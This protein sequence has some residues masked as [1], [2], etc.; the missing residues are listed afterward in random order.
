[1]KFIIIAI[2]FFNL[3]TLSFKILMVAMLLSGSAVIG[4]AIYHHGAFDDRCVSENT[5]FF[6]S[7]DKKWYAKVD[8]LRC[9]DRS[10]RDSVSLLRQLNDRISILV[11][12]SA[13]NADTAN[14]INMMKV[15]W[16]AADQ[17]SI[18]TPSKRDLPVKQYAGINVSYATY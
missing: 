4:N 7:P 14:E 9:A 15:V 10:G 16:Q 13:S 11:Y 6:P 17:L 18:V 5:L 1:M 3:K 8:R 2:T 12:S